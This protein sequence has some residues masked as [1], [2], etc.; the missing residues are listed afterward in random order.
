MTNIIG[1]SS[2]AG[3]LTTY[4]AT[5]AFHSHHQVKSKKIESCS[6]KI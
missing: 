1:M 4:I 5:L 2:W 6:I 3:E